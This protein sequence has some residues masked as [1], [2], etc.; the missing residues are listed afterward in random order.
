MFDSS[1]AGMLKKNIM[2]GG[3]LE[4]PLAYDAVWAMALGMHNTFI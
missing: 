1:Y 2:P 3:Y 4:A